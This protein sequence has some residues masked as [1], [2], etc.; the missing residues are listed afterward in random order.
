MSKQD[1]IKASNGEQCQRAA[2]MAAE[3]S[4]GQMPFAIAESERI[5]EFTF[6]VYFCSGDNALLS[7]VTLYSRNV[8]Y[9]AVKRAHDQVD[10]IA[11]ANGTNLWNDEKAGNT[12]E[13]RRL[14]QHYHDRI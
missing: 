14:H 6:E 12:I 2:T 8:N 4:Q 11:G 3:R 13:T 7:S 1:L 10:N 9:H 5:G